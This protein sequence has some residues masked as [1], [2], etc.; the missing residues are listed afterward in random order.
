MFFPAHN[1]TKKTQA[2]RT[3]RTRI[4]YG[5]CVAGRIDPMAT[6]NALFAVFAVTDPVGAAAVEER[7]LTISPWLYLKVGAGEWLVIAPPATT[8]KE[9][10]DRI[11]L[12]TVDP[13]ASGIVVRAEGYFGRH[14]QS[15]WEW[16]ATKQ[17]AELG[18][19][20]PVQS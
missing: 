17:G 9:L 4:A 2:H 5:E 15:V 14:S 19:A 8:S 12:G 6:P 7:L 10:C 20:A 3:F 1:D 18:T 16:I 11:G 13:I